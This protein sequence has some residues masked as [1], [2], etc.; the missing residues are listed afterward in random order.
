MIPLYSLYTP[1][2]RILKE[3]FFEPTLPDDVELRLQ[4]Y[5]NDGNGFIG[6]ASF[7]RAIVRKVEVILEAIRENWGRIF[8]WSD[9]DVQFFAPIRDWAIAA[10]HELDMAFQ[11]DAPGPSLCAGFFFCRGNEDT[12]RLW[13]DTLELTLHSNRGE[14]DQDHLRAI[15]WNGRRLRWG[16]LPPVFIGGGTFTRKLWKPGDEFPVPESVVAHHANFTCGVPNKIRQCEYVL[17]KLQRN[18][19][20]PVE[21]AYQLFGGPGK[22][23]DGPAALRPRRA[24]L[25]PGR[26]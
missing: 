19:V 9:V 23:P 20:I 26:R 6:G 7:Q 21:R 1:S 11:I 24:P 2:H 4:Y 13:Q 14:N 12:L 22:F 25:I 8:I 15:L 3:R 18:D 16:H 5:E 10:T 17:N